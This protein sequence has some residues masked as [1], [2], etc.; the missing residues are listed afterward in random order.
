MS[1]WSDLAKLLPDSIRA[2]EGARFSEQLEAQYQRF[3]GPE[4]TRTIQLACLLANLVSLPFA[5]LDR[6][7]LPDSYWISWL[8]RIACFVFVTLVYIDTRKPQFLERYTFTGFALFTMLGLM[9]ELQV[10]ISSPGDIARTVYA[11]GLILTIMGMY[12]LSFLSV[13]VTFAI[14]V[15][16]VLIYAATAFGLHDAVAQ[17]QVSIVI[18]NMLLMASAGVI[19]LV[20]QVGRD[21][22]ERQAFLHKHAMDN[23]LV[24]TDTARRLSEH[25]AR[26]D[27][28]TGLPNRKAFE[29][30]LTQMTRDF[31]PQAREVAVLFVDL[32]GFK[33]VNDQFGHAFGDRVLYVIGQRINATIG[34]RDLA[35]RVG[36]DE[37]VV[38][39]DLL[40]S[41]ATAATASQA[42]TEIADRI[43]V[44]VAQPIAIDQQIVTVGASV[45]VALASV[46]GANPAV[47][48]TIADHAMYAV[49]HGGKG[50]ARLA[51]VI[52]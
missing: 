39:L 15:V 33:L 8:V 32:D 34:E 22:Y 5:L 51:G 27:A 3:I 9:I 52:A 28:L 10:L 43:V 31:L 30:R 16:F 44:V 20:T 14:S 13:A 1:L 23:E 18:T 37:F 42:A 45:G 35:A 50:A 49:K 19:G 41:T 4:K 25:Y 48:M 26:H 12:S 29:D 21:Q 11:N 46:H 38:A 36:G 47:L 6:W 7:A 24:A 17:G 2:G 40:P